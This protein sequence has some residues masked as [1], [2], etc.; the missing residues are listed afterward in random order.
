M[1]DEESTKTIAPASR[2]DMTT[3]IRDITD[4]MRSKILAVFE[5]ERVGIGSD[6]V[7]LSIEIPE[8]TPLRWLAAQKCDEKVYWGGRDGKF[9]VAGIGTADSVMP[10]AASDARSIISAIQD[11]L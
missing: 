7:R 3:S 1:R 5:N 11:R 8:Q 10:N 9:V 4:V 2:I 6:P